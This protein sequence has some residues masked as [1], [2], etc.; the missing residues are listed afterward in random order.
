M[1]ANLIALRALISAP[2]AWRQSAPHPTNRHRRDH[3]R[4]VVKRER[5]LPAA[6]ASAGTAR[7]LVR[8]AAAQAGLDPEG[9]WDLMLA[10]SEA[11]ANAVQHGEA[12][13]NACILLSTEPC[14][15]G[16]RVE[17]CDCGSFDSALEPAPL[18]AT[19]GRGIPIIAAVVDRLEVHNGGG[20]TRV[21]FERH[22]AAA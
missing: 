16:L 15:R 6:A 1:R 21:C 3:S 18:E 20:R 12:W 2:R 22:T 17:V 8:E 10:T 14:A 5:W 4:G 9:T 13:P 19:S 7:S 11:V